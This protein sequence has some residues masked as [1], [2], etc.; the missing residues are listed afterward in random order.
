MKYSLSWKNYSKSQIITMNAVLCALVLTFVFFPVKIG[1]LSLA[2]IPLIAVVIAAELFGFVNGMLMGLFFG[3]CSL[4]YNFTQPG[5]LSFA[6]Y[7]PMVSIVPRILIGL[8]SYFSAAG[9]HTLFIKIAEK[10][11]EKD[12]E[13]AEK[14][15]FFTNEGPDLA[16]NAVGAFCGVVTNTVGV[17]GMIL[18]FY[19]G[20]PFGSSGSAIGW[21]WLTAIIL[22]NSILEVAVCTVVTPPLVLAVKKVVGKMARK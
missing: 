7:N 16:A 19:F 3:I 13:K 4:I 11:R 1:I 2:V 5:V 6:F 18:A 17:L 12:P 8:T 20:T 10:K 21:P 15:N 22:S 9:V 14:S